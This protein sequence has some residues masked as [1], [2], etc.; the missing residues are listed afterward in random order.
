MRLPINLRDLTNPQEVARLSHYLKDLYTKVNLV[1][2]GTDAPTITPQR[3]GDEF[4]DTAHKKL[5][6]ATGTSSSADWTL[7][8]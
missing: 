4:V 1:T 8:N 2:L 6:K 7:V 5:Y 3:I